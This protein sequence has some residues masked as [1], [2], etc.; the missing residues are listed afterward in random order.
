MK[1]KN[2]IQKVTCSLILDAANILYHSESTDVLQDEYHYTVPIIW[3]A[4]MYNWCRYL[5]FSSFLPLFVTATLWYLCCEW[6][7]NLHLMHL[8]SDTV[9]CS[10]SQST[11]NRQNCVGYRVCVWTRGVGVC[12]S[13]DVKLVHYA[14]AVINTG[15]KENEGERMKM[16]YIYLSSYNILIQLLRYDT[17]DSYRAFYWIRRTKQSGYH[18]RKSQYTSYTRTLGMRFRTHS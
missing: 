10:G 8:H 4:S 14:G 12:K 2:F 16:E 15:G 17:F 6:K 7:P 5:Y 13:Q 18:L 11:G 3:L 1:K 9:A